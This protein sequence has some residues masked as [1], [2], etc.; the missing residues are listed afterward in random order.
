MAHACA[1]PA[2]DLNGSGPGEQWINVIDGSKAP[3]QGVGAFVMA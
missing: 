1:R 3:T 2:R